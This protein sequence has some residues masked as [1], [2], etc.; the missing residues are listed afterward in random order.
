M[1]PASLEHLTACYLAQRPLFYGLIRPPEARLF[2]QHARFFRPRMLDFGCGDGFFC[3][4]AAGCGV[5]DVGLD[6]AGSRL[7][8]AREA[9]VYKAVVEYDGRCIPFADGY[10][11]TVISNS[12][13]EHV[14]DLEVILHEIQRVLKPGGTLLTTVMTDRWNEYLLGA[15][16]LGNAYR[17]WMARRQQHLHLLSLQQWRAAFAHA[18]FAVVATQGYLAKSTARLL[19]LLHYL[20]VPALLSQAL[21]KRWVLFP[22]LLRRSPLAAALARC[23][24]APV[25]AEHSAALFFQLQKQPL[26]YKSTAPAKA[27]RVPAPGS[28]AGQ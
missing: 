20:S 14:R 26:T 19:D 22:G 15:Y 3:S 24:R 5:V 16:L 27:A 18:G 12:V 17:T 4:L 10:F 25:A 7:C 8:A 6:V 1:A 13:L 2:Q 23:R 28:I 9:G 21:F 11:Q